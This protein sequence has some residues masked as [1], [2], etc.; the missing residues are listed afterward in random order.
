MT[1]LD[2]QAYKERNMFSTVD[3]S[4]YFNQESEVSEFFSG[5]KILITGGSGFLG[6]LILEKLLR[7]CPKI[8]R[9]YLLMR[10]KKQKDMQTRFKEYFN[11]ILFERLKEE[12][13]DVEKKIVL[14]ESDMYEL[15]LGMSGKDS[16]RIKDTEVIFHCAAS[17]RFND[18]LRSIINVNVR[19]TRDLL[20][21][22]QEMPNLKVFT[23]V[24]TAYS[25][26]IY[27]RIE[28]KYYNPPLKTEDIIKLTET[29]NDHQ[30]ELITP[31]LLGKWP[32][33]YTYSKAI[34]EDTVR[35]YSRGFPTC[36]VRPSS[37]LATE[38]DP[39]PG[40]TNN[41]YGLT[42]I[43]SCIGLGIIRVMNLNTK[44]VHDI[45][46]ADYAVNNIIVST[47]D[48][49]KKRSISPVITNFNNDDKSLTVDA[50]EIPIYNIVSYVQ[51]PVKWSYCVLKLFEIES[52]VPLRKCLWYPFFLPLTNEY[53]VY[54]CII[55]LHWIPG[56]IVDSL[57]LL[58]GRKPRLL[59]IYRKI[60]KLTNV[61]N[62]FARNQ[63][64]FT[65]DNVLKLWNKLSVVDK[66]KFFFN[67]SDLD[68]D[69]YFLTYCKGVRVFVLN[70][71]LETVN[72]AKI[73]H[74]RLR[75]IHYTTGIVLLI[76]LLW[77]LYLLL[78]FLY[79]SLF[80]F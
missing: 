19:G 38:K 57:A 11:D 21:L 58:V 52:I 32:N 65:N 75:I 29:L 59:N 26:C 53:F 73:L 50:E 40:W 16:E 46:P 56:F 3:E 68:W 71:P 39:I 7:S 51:N 12:Q 22:A 10:G 24:S 37:V 23:Y 55:L 70:D 74:E 61:M 66:N 27:E 34:C 15:N 76:L 18:T 43:A 42:G 78:Q 4:N 77:G 2:A 64:E 44:L 62:F 36:I 20:L 28:E 33:T 72:D 67:I 79:T 63:W 49:A 30:L 45:I 69:S 14:I 1:S 17:V 41:L 25:Q 35:Q 48:I 80:S 31:E 9:I 6:R 60:H 5:R 54:L 13:K 8:E 47:W